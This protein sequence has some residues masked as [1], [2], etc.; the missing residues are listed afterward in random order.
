MLQV[1]NFVL[2]RNENDSTKN[3]GAL[4]EDSEDCEVTYGKRRLLHTGR[5]IQ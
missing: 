5:H 1:I 3:H 2:G 4:K